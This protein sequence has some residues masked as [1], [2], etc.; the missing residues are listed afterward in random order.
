MSL[1]TG[2]CTRQDVFDLGLSA[3]AY[4]V[5]ARPVGVCDVDVDSGQVRLKGHGLSP[6][7][8]ISF[9]VTTGGVLP[10]EFQDFT[11]PRGMTSPIPLTFDTFQ[12]ATGPESGVSIQP[13]SSA[14]NGWSVAVDAGRRIDV[15]IL[16]TASVINDKLIAHATPFERDVA[17]NYP[18][19]I[20]RLNAILAAM[21]SVSTLLFENAES[22][23]SI[24]ILVEKKARA[25]ADLA[26]YLAGKPVL[27]KPTDQTT[28]PD[29][30]A[31]AG[32][33]RHTSPWETGRL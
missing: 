22:R 12:V 17:G 20:V 6:R 1:F 27:P 11:F 7:D 16:S 31:R 15:N 24:D 19:V 21:D 18:P 28:T 2:Y 14:G 30:A 26:I 4:V 5:R 32:S 10:V 13:L 25:E 33:A 9:E 23:K 3:Q 29:N 8:L